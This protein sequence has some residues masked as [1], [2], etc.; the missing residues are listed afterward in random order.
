MPSWSWSTVSQTRKPQ[1]WGLWEQVG[2]GFVV[3]WAYMIQEHALC[4]EA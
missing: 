4:I 1:T 3:N 2:L